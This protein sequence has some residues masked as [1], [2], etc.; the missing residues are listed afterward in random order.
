MAAI[1]RSF[2]WEQPYFPSFVSRLKFH[3]KPVRDLRLFLSLNF[4][5]VPC[6]KKQFPDLANVSAMELLFIKWYWRDLFY[7]QN[8]CREYVKSRVSK[9]SRP[10]WHTTHTGFYSFTVKNYGTER[11]WESKTLINRGEKTHFWEGFSIKI[12]AHWNNIPLQVTLAILWKIR[13]TWG[14]LLMMI[15]VTFPSGWQQIG[16]DVSLTF[17]MPCCL[18]CLDVWKGANNNHLETKN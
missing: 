17:I 12:P 6:R 13:A 10:H 8:Y 7:I 5:F 3:F 2:C 11:N 4:I 18:V 16:V 1:L 14:S 9:V 15:P